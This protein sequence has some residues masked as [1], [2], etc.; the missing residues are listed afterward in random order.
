MLSLI[1]V[2]F[3]STADCP[4][5]AA[6]THAAEVAD[7]GD[8]VMGFDHD[9]T[10]HSFRIAADGGSIEVVA[11]DAGDAKSITAIRTHLQDVAKAFA[12]G[13]FAKPEAIHGRIPDGAQTMRDRK[14]SIRYRY[15]ELPAGARVVISTKN[16]EA[17]AAIH[18]FLR[19]QIDEH[20]TA[21]PK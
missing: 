15:E 9:R 7:R 21:D 8:A 18:Q 20:G 11:N 2:L 1:A 19:F 5:H 4:M 17:L 14:D 10:K 12:A 6:H 13:D 16:S 3:L